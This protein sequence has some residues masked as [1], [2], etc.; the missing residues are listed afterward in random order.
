MQLTDETLQILHANREELRDHFIY[1][2]HA[3]VMDPSANICAGIRW[4]FQK[5]VIAKERYAEIDP[6]HNVTWEDA[7]A[8]YKGV[9]SGILDK[10]N[11]HPDPEGKMPKFRSIY[12]KFQD[13][14]V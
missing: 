9:L 14:V 12:E 1:L 8:E 7:V 10:N 13:G 6:G 2:S 4:L 5:K 11:P 3:T